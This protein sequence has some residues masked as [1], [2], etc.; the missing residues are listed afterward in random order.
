MNIY[1][2][3]SGSDPQTSVSRSNNGTQ[4]DIVFKNAV[5]GLMVD[6]AA[7]NGPISQAISSR[8]KGFGS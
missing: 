4:V 1:N 3:P 5:T 6:D 8:Q 2:A 7:R